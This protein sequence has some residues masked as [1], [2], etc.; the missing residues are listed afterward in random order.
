VGS[1]AIAM[2]RV[3]RT[4]GFQAGIA[5]AGAVM[6]FMLLLFNVMYYRTEK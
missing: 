4:Y 2:G 1:T 5:L 3:I 6:L